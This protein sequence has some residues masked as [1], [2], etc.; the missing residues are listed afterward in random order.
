MGRRQLHLKFK[1]YYPILYQIRS[2][3]RQN[4]YIFMKFSQTPQPNSCYNPF[5]KLWFRFCISNCRHF[6]NTKRLPNLLLTSTATFYLSFLD[7]N[8]CVLFIAT[9]HREI[10]CRKGE[11]E[12]DLSVKDEQRCA[13]VRTVGWIGLR[14][15]PVVGPWQ[16]RMAFSVRRCSTYS[17][18]ALL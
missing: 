10:S 2:G 14:R 11:R 17:W 9:F 18:L 1:L 8:D 16:F 5:F 4:T 12:R 6:R 15:A 3:R 13:I 7:L